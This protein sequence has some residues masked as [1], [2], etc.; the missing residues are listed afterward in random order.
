MEFSK[1]IEVDIHDVDYNGIARLSSLMRYIQTA[2]QSQL[3]ANGLSYERLREMGRAFI[4][5]RITMEFTE[6]VRAYDRLEAITFPCESRG[7]SFLRCYSL[8]RDGITLGRAASIWALVDVDTRKLQRVDSFELG[9]KTHSPHELTVARFS[10][11]HTLREVGKYTVSYGETDQNMHMNN[12]K[13]PD[14][15]STF[16]PLE[17]K[18]I[19]TI[20]ISYLNEAPLG[21]KLTVY[22]TKDQD[23]VY[24]MRT[25]R[26]DGKVNTEAQIFL[27]DIVD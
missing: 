7:F 25:V 3:T 2:A 18:R 13:Y 15:Y 20:T 9:L 12:T 24:Y 23:G 8:V 19:H 16:L 21:E 22:S 26:E 1:R 17:G 14:I 4:L 6:M 11:P 5:S 27:V 10:V